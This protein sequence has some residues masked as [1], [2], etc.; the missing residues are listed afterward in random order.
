MTSSPLVRAT[1]VLVERKSILLVKQVLKERSHWSLPG[2]KLEYGETLEQCLVREMFEE[3][4]LNVRPIELLY[5]CDRFKSLNHHV[6]DIS[7][8]VTPVGK[9]ALNGSLFGHK[10][11]YLPE[12]KMAPFCHLESYGFSEKFIG[13]LKEGFPDKGSYQGDFHAFYG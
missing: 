10:D 11:E 3:T 2:G 4:G 9:L 13:L 5:I 8:L 12:V 6:L 7:F 1:G